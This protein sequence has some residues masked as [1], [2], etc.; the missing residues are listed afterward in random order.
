MSDGPPPNDPG[1][2]TMRERIA[3]HLA[4]PDVRARLVR[5]VAHKTPASELE[6]TIAAVHLAI[7]TATELPRNDDAIDPWMNG[8]AAEHGA[9]AARHSTRTRKRDA[10]GE[11]MDTVAASDR[12]ELPDEEPEILPWLER[13]VRGNATDEETVVILLDKSA[14]GLTYPRAAQAHG[15]TE[16]TLKKRVGRL[17][18]KHLEA[19][20]RHKDKRALLLRSL[21]WGAAIIA[22]VAAIFVA[23]LL[24][25]HPHAAG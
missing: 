25:R 10:R 5:I 18:A 21:K 23:W 22:A 15:L 19:W 14:R 3:A 1:A 2:A 24:L 12:A 13:R 9:K 17:V 4:K 7:R 11:D 20:E 16:A 6:D 8:I